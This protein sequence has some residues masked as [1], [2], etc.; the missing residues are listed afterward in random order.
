MRPAT[1]HQLESYLPFSFLHRRKWW[2]DDDCSHYAY[3]RSMLKM[4][5]KLLSADCGIGELLPDVSRTHGVVFSHQCTI[6]L[7]VYHWCTTGVPL[8]CK[9]TTGVPL[10]CHRPAGLTLRDYPAYSWSFSTRAS[11]NSLSTR[12]SHINPVTY[13]FLSIVGLGGQGPR[14]ASPDTRSG[15]IH[16]K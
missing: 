10:V 2:T 8:A 4:G 5:L 11:H 6:G 7:L 14:H 12:A 9:C 16:S 13:L 3:E 15:W 1:Y